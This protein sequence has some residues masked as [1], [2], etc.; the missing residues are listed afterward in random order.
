MS[1][2]QAPPEQ[3]ATPAAPAPAR[4]SAHGYLQRVLDSTTAT[5]VVAIVIALLVAAVLVVAADPASQRAAGYF[6]ARPGDFLSAAWD[7]VYSTYSALFRG[8]IFDY[9][10]EGARRI[11]PITETMVASVP[12]MLAGL[13]LAIGFRSGLFNI[14]AQGQ[15]LVGGGAAAWVGMTLDLPVGVHVLV[16]CVAAV[17][18]GGVWA[19]IAGFLKARTGAS[20]VIVT[21]M[22]NSV[23]GYLAAYLLTTAV[24]RQPGS[25]RPISAPVQDT[26]VMPLL[27]G[28]QFR[29]HL[30]FL[31]AVAAAFGVWW[32]M[33]RSTLGFRFRAVGANQDAARTAGIR[34]ERM[35][36]LVMLVAGGLAGLGGA[37]QILGTDRTFQASSAGAIGFDAIT[38]AL[39][40]RSRPLGTALAALLFGA[41]RA[42]SPLMQ[43]AAGTPIDLVQVI[44]AVIVLLIAAPPLVRELSL[45]HRTAALFGY[46]RKK[47]TA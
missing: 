34:V 22:L 7:A 10:A 4:Q 2:T 16:A 27:L 38:V 21:I 23:A 3:P 11:R 46:D 33:E 40:G 41:L 31:V 28:E 9:E 1:A 29:L 12:L 20:E 30:G 6:F 14:G 44:Q 8:S 37:M 25:T 47:A 15:V 35:Y 32:L 42:G 39:L 36:V 24:L 45:A 17:A 13:G 26:A 5:V 43:T 19:G 18:L